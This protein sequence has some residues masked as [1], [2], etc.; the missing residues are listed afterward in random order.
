MLSDALKVL[1]QPGLSE[2]DI[3]RF[4]RVISMA[5]RYQ[6]LLKAYVKFLQLQVKVAEELIS[7]AEG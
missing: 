2:A 6:K 3:K 5:R 4:Y 7:S 1:S